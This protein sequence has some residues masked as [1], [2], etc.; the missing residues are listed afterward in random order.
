MELHTAFKVDVNFRIFIA[1]RN[2]E[3]IFVNCLLESVRPAMVICPRYIAQCLGFMTPNNVL[4]R[5]R[6]MQKHNIS[7][8]VLKSNGISTT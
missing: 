8:N 7:L 3:I 2:I 4:D 1:L 6:L 5:G